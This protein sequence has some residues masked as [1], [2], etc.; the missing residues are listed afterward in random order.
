MA[1]E[2]T[3]YVS[4]YCKTQALTHHFIIS[5]DETLELFK[6]VCHEETNITTIIPLLM[7]GA[8]VR[9]SS[10]DLILHVLS[11]QACVRA[12]KARLYGMDLSLDGNLEEVLGCIVLQSHA[13]EVCFPLGNPQTSISQFTHLSPLL[14][15]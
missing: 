1:V 2:E 8:L 5:P 13:S 3:R 9:M 12:R 6:C 10:V 7:Q 14:T 4:L 11:F 15:P